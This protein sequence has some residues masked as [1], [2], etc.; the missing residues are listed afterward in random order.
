MASPSVS[1]LM[2]CLEPG[3]FLEEAIDSALADPAVLELLVAD[4]GSRDGSLERL[5]A[6]A[7]TDHRVRLVS[8]SDRGPA[9]AL[10]RALPHARGTVIGWLNADDRY[11]SG[12]ASRAVAALRE[13]PHWLM[14]YGE[15][16]HI[17]AEGRRIDRYPTRGPEVGLAGFRDYCFL[18]QPTV[19]WRRTLSLLVGPWDTSLRCAF[20]FDYWIR[21]FRAAPGRIGA[22]QALQAQ[23]R[24]HPDTL[25]ATQLGRAVLEATRLQARHLSDPTAHI[26]LAYAEQVLEGETAPPQGEDPLEHLSG[27]LQELRSD[28]PAALWDSVRASLPEVA[29][30]WQSAGEGG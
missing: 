8:R 26:L 12:A 19:F 24:R 6:R 5:E 7:R 23:T 18:C 10:N 22:L 13:N 17:D 27:L 28:L 30:Q 25:S 14:V 4:G 11:L 16:E 21:A 1:V 20:D 15:G 3:R 9:D 29:Q 2:P